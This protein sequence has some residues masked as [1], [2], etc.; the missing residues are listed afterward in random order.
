MNDY[1]SVISGAYGLKRSTIRKVSD[2][3]YFID[4]QLNLL[5]LVYDGVT[6]TFDQ[7]LIGTLINIRGE[8]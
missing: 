3:Q 8:L 7:I 4:E 2:K 1:I 6:I 5:P